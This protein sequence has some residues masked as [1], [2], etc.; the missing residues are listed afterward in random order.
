MFGPD[1]RYNHPVLQADRITRTEPAI[2][3]HHILVAHVQV[4]LRYCQRSVPQDLLQYYRRS[5]LSDEVGSGAVTNQV[6][7][8]RHS[9]LVADFLNYLVAVA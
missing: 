9:G 4:V 2:S 3:I 7:V 6:R 1:V 8:Q 5:T